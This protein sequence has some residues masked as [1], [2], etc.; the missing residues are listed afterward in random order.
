MTMGE[1]HSSPILKRLEGERDFFL[2]HFRYSPSIH[3]I[4]VIP[5][6]F[7]IPPSFFQ[8]V[9]TIMVE[10]RYSPSIPETL[11]EEWILDLLPL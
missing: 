7:R 3:P 9:A 4:F 10:N 8:I 5:L 1:A 11:G 2:P 6:Y